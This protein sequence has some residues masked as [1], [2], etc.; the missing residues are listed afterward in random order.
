MS[1]QQ[2][3]RHPRKRPYDDSSVHPRA[4]Q[5]RQQHQQQQQQ[6]RQKQSVWDRLG[7]KPPPESSDAASSSMSRDRR[8]RPI[9]ESSPRQEPIVTMSIKGASQ[10]ARG[11]PP[12][13]IVKLEDDRT[14]ATPVGKSTRAEPKN[15]SAAK[16]N[17]SLKQNEPQT[18]SSTSRFHNEPRT[19]AAA[20]PEPAISTS[21]IWEM[22]HS[23]SSGKPYYYNR[24]T[25]KSVWTEPAGFDGGKRSELA[26]TSRQ[27]DEDN[28][29]MRV[30]TDEERPDP[31]VHEKEDASRAEGKGMPGDVPS[32]EP[33]E[34]T[35]MKSQVLTPAE[36][37]PKTRAM[38]AISL[39]QI[40]WENRYGVRISVAEGI[41]NISKA[42]RDPE[43]DAFAAGIDEEE[44]RRSKVALVEQMLTD[45]EYPPW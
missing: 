6:N 31:R 7:D 45:L 5:Q 43:L 17:L 44:C 14:A 29:T 33:K 19:N 36:L 21:D 11:E 28:T 15:Q 8:R 30:D 38:E 32:D 4:S 1:Q 13:R 27:H 18:S 42:R 25:G 39:P 3:K 16:S 34:Q 24:I 10:A 37:E 40:R 41:N 20:E 35:D 9:N 22:C 12:R 26:E 23:R 2:G